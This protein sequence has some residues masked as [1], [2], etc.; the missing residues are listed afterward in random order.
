MIVR[1]EEG[2]L[3]D[4]L[5]SLEGEVDEIVIVD[6]GSR[7]RTREIALARGARLFEREWTGDFSAARNYALERAQADWI[8]YIDADER[9]ETP[10]PGALRAALDDEGA[11]ACWVKFQPRVAFTPYRE[12]RLFRSDPRIRF[13]GAIHESVLP[14]I[15]RVMSS[16]GLAMR[17]VDIG[18]RH[19]GYEGDL[20]HK[21]HRNLP[22]LDLALEK[23]P[24]RVFL[25]VDKAQA[26]SGLGRRDEAAR[27]CRTAIALAAADSS[28]KQRNDGALAWSLL[29]GFYLD[30]DPKQAAALAARAVEAYPDH[31]GLVLARANALY[32]AGEAQA[33]LPFL[34]R[35]IA[36]DPQTV[37]DPLT[38]FDKRI[39]G[40]WA[41]QLMGAAFMRLNRIAEAGAAFAQAARLSGAE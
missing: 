26:L 9:L 4:C 28:P 7:D 14:D 2:F 21:F 41:Y 1:D 29:I 17:D 15:N 25:W 12:L 36:I 22:L 30:D 34:Q 35:L 39:F 5:K 18:I 23:D 8:L 31:Y 3:D 13:R 6:T 24:K 37:F 40:E 16:D 19:I 27:A 20:T 33:A 11:V 32:A 38:A 10:Y